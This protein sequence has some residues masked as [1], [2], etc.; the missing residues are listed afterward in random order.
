MVSKAASPLRKV[1]SYSPG[2]ANVHHR[3]KKTFFTFLILVTFFNVLTFF[4]FPNVFLFKKT[5]FILK[6]R[7]Q[8]SERQAD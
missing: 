4:Y 6:K 5:F 3:C 7:W 1:Q 2:G 8:S